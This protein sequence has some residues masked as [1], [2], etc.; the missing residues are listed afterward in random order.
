MLAEQR[1]EQILQV[2]QQKR[3]VGVPELCKATGASEATIRRDLN[4]LDRQGRLSKVHGGAVLPDSEFQR[5]EPDV[6]TKLQLFIAQKDRIAR[7]AASLVRDDDVVFLDAGTTTV[8][9]VDYL[10]GTGAILVTNGI[11]CAQQMLNNHLNGFILGGCLKPGTDAIVGTG[12]VSD[13]S[14]YNFTKAFLGI[15]GITVRQGFTT[16]DVEEAAVKTG[17]AARA[18]QVF[19]LAD[20]SKFG[21]VTAATVLPIESASIITEKL[22]EAKYQEHTTILEAKAK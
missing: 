5:D 3:A 10:T 17:A 13:L 12:A 11:A 14:R 21:I 2:L 9:M 20:S 18:Q 22:P 19:V 1:F 6:A 8:R 7:H 4:T 16:P 15:N